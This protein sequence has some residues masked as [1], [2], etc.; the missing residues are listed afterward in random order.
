MMAVPFSLQVVEKVV[1][2]VSLETLAEV[3]KLVDAEALTLP[4]P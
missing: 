4:V 2:E 3:V 1:Y